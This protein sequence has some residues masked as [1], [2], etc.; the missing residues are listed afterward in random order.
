MQA[1]RG[2]GDELRRKARRFARLLV[3]EI[4][5]YN[6]SKVAEGRRDRDIYPRLKEEIEHSRAIY[7]KRY[8]QTPVSGD[9]LFN[10]EVLENLAGGDPS[11]LGGCMPR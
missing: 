10:K 3:D 7:D 2:E 6:E 11:L 1:Q 8:A 9:D 4:R 5:L